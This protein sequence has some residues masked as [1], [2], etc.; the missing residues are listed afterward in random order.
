MSHLNIDSSTPL[1][2]VAENWDGQL[3]FAKDGEEMMNIILGAAVLQNDTML[4][5]DSYGGR[6]YDA[7]GERTRNPGCGYG[8]DYEMLSEPDDVD[9]TDEGGLHPGLG[10]ILFANSP[11]NQS[12]EP[13]NDHNYRSVL[14][15]TNR[16][17]RRQNKN[18]FTKGVSSRLMPALST[19]SSSQMSESNKLIPFGG[20]SAVSGDLG[21]GI[22]SAVVDGSR[23]ETILCPY[24]RPQRRKRRTV[25]HVR[26]SLCNAPRGNIF[27]FWLRLRTHLPYW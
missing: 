21:L 17:L 20:L 23:Y 24:P 16:R 18:P 14:S 15:S 7:R 11:F 27:S 12:S 3:V 2:L 10:P 19:S 6:Q 25:Q 1:P 26:T 4:T 9:T 5:T 22:S 13:P 8:E